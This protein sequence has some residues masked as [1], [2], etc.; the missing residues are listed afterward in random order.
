[1]RQIVRFPDEGHGT[2]RS[3]GTCS[4]QQQLEN[5]RDGA[6][7]TLCPQD[8]LTPETELFHCHTASQKWGEKGPHNQVQG[9]GSFHLRELST[10]K[11]PPILHLQHCTFLYNCFWPMGG[12]LPT[13][14][15]SNIVTFFPPSNIAQICLQTYCRASASS[16]KIMDVEVPHECRAGHCMT[17]AL[18]S[19]SLSSCN[20][21]HPH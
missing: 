5:E 19:T 11:A 3:T 2:E 21:R 15:M 20:Y 9:V 10:S 17:P 16:G 7:D 12:H 18:G 8:I 14:I 4:R 1:M 13:I 6:W